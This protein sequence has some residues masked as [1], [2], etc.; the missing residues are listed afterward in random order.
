LR[1]GRKAF[2][3]VNK[4]DGSLCVH[5][6]KGVMRNGKAIVELPRECRDLVPGDLVWDMK[7]LGIVET[8]HVVLWKKVWNDQDRRRRV[9]MFKF[10]LATSD[11]VAVETVMRE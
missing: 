9:F 6:L 10:R 2:L 1:K 7:I 4:E 3:F 11:E 8:L 5:G